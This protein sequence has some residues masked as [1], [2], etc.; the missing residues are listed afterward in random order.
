MVLSVACCSPFLPLGIEL[1]ES[2]DYLM[3]KFTYFF[4]AKQVSVRLDLSHPGIIAKFV[5]MCRMKQHIIRK[6]RSVAEHELNA[7]LNCIIVPNLIRFHI[8]LIGMAF[9][10][11]RRTVDDIHSPAIRLPPFPK[12]GSVLCVGIG[13]PSKIFLFGFVDR[14]CFLLITGRPEFMHCLPLAV[15]PL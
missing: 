5:T 7:P 8:Q 3:V 2:V 9:D 14:R 12:T 6:S 11:I 4:V 1:K 15:N 13:N 10:F